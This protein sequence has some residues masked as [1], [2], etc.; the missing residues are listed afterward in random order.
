MKQ[1]PAIIELKRKKIDHTLLEYELPAD[2]Y[3][4]LTICRLN[5]LDPER[6]L[7][8]L[9]CRDEKSGAAAVFVL[10]SEMTLDIRKAAAAADLKSIKMLPVKEL[11]PL[12]GYVRGG[13]SPLGMKKKLPVFIEETIQIH[14]NIFINAGQRGLFLEMKTD[15]LLNTTEAVWQDIV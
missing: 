12:T 11:E 4:A 6:V 15:D 3:D 9:V 14:S 8:T 2:N 7:K 13:C 1:S 5:N 10:P